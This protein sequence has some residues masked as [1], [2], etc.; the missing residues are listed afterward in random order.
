MSKP[1]TSW[2]KEEDQDKEVPGQEQQGERLG[3]LHLKFTGCREGEFTCDDGQCVRMEKRYFLI[4]LILFENLSAGVTN[5]L[6][7][8]TTLTREAASCWC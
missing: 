3:V 6:T 5:F 4:K 2:L 8:L 7:V 1:V